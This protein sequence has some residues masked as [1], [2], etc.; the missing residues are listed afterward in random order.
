MSDEEINKRVSELE[1]ILIGAKNDITKKERCFPTMLVVGVSAPVVI[2]LAFYFIK[3]SFVQK[4]EADGTYSRDNKKVLLYTFIVSLVIWA[5]L[6]L[7]S[8]YQGNSGSIFECFK[9]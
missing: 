3:P 7:W 8:Y 2:W 6:Y 9:K 4:Q 1:N 5:C